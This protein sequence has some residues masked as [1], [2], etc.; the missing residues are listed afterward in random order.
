MAKGSAMGLWKG[1]KG[2]SVFYQIKNSNSLQKQGVRERN[3][4]PANPQTASQAG[5]RMRMYPA[6]A[7]YGAIKDIIERSWQGAK[8][9][10]MSRQAYLKRALRNDIFPAIQKG[11]GIAAVPG[12]YQIAK[13]SLNEVVCD[14]STPGR[15][16]FSIG[17]GNDADY[18]TMLGALSQSL[19]ETTG[20]L[21]NGD[22]L[23]FVVVSSVTGGQFIWRT[24]SFILN[25]SDNE[26]PM[27][28][29]FSLAGFQTES[30]VVLR[31]NI[32]FVSG[33]DIFV[34]AACIVSRE[35]TTPLRSSATLA[36]D[37]SAG[38][39]QAYYSAEAVASSKRSYMK[40]LSVQQTDW[41]VDPSEGEGG[42]SGDDYTITVNQVTTQ[43]GGTEDPTP[44]G[45]V[46]GGGSY[47]IGERVTLTATADAQHIFTGWYPSKADALANTNRISTA[48]VYIFV[49]G[50]EHENVTTF[51]GKFQP[52]L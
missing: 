39:M 40:P 36:C 44:G 33:N 41:P 27:G 6:Q 20:W 28:D 46:S 23:T 50:D 24:V 18:G 38:E 2:S 51:Y 16:V 5:Q 49:A 10:Q 11:M 47:L 9:G 34:A 21:Q 37:Y 30:E 31:N 4:E 45:V 17:G 13:G 26:T 15:F 12:P 19:I 3:Y 32:S 1:K 35:G 52:Q 8:Y 25:T 43:A 22:Q 14:T 29:I 7:V 48:G 42:G